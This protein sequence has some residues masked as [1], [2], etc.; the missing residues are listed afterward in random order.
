[1][2]PDDSSGIT[3]EICDDGV[4]FEV[5]G[6][7]PGHLGLRSM[8]ERASRLG[9]TLEVQ[10]APNKGTRICTRIPV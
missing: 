7:Y 3:L 9:G 1:M 4:G 6:E 8:H 5:K 10:S 2:K